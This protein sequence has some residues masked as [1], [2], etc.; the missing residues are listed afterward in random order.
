MLIDTIEKL[1]SVKVDLLSCS[2]P[3]VDT[4]TTGLNI[5][6]SMNTEP[7]RIIGISIDTGNEAYY[8]PFRHEQGQ[9]LPMSVMT[10]FFVPYLSNDDRVYGGFNYKYDMHMLKHDGVPYVSNI[11]DAMLA[12]HLLNENE[13]TFT[14]KGL[15][16]KYGIGDGSLQE[17]EL[18]EKI[19]AIRPDLTP[20]RAKGFMKLLSPADVEPYACDDVRLTRGLLELCVPALKY[21]GLYDIWKEVNYYSYITNH[22]ESRGIMLDV[23]LINQYMSEAGD[24]YMDAQAR[25]DKEAGYPV[26]ANSSKQVCALLGVDSSASE[27]LEVLM[28]SDTPQGQLAKTV[29]ECR[30]WKSVASRYY[31]PY[32]NSM[33]KEH[34]LHTN[35][36]LIG[37]VSGRLSCNNPNLQAVA[38]KTE[39]FKVKNVFRAREGYKLVSADYKQAEMRLATWYANEQNMAKLIREGQDLHS[40]TAE[41]LDIPR[42]AAKRIN[43]GVIYGI[44]AGA[45]SKQLRIDESV[46]RDYL[47]KYHGLYKGFRRLMNSCEETANENGYIRMWSGRMRHYDENNPTHK[48]MSN[49]VQGGI[50]EV[51]RTTISR[52]FPA[53][54]DLGG[55][56]VLQVHDQ[57]MFEIPEENLDVALPLISKIMNDFP[58]DPALSVDVE[59]GDSWGNL[60]GWEPQEA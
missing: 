21:W 11:E 9:N 7:D 8:F 24:H 25:L 1:N 16:D 41:M 52:L 36:N 57:V 44:G 5:W 46:A 3:V 35:L 51:M 39:V 2:N 6:G 28:E 37:T 45:L 26:N 4:E 15:A 30:G 12:V 17:S 38:R 42:D 13:S 55:Y 49:L 47:K 33:T 19:L 58:F 18:V 20:K 31:T 59:Y 43:F 34:V 53:I 22:M 32:L 56:M 50:A 54:R 27:I 40:A 10:D 14:L 60:T 48:A 23:D 29:V